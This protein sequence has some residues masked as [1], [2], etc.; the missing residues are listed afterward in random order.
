MSAQP[1]EVKIVSVNT[2][3]NNGCMHSLLQKSPDTDILI[4]QEPWFYTVATVRSDEDPEGTPQKGL[5]HNDMWDA[6]TPKHKT[7]D[8]CKVAIYTHKSLKA[9]YNIKL[10]TDHCLASLTTMVLDLTDTERSTL[11]I[12][13]VYHKRLPRGH[14]LHHLLTHTLDE[15][16]PTILIGDFNTHDPQWSRPTQTPTSWGMAFTEWNDREGLTCLNP[17]D[18]LT[19]FHPTIAEHASIIDLAFANEAL[20]LGGQL[21]T[22]QILDGPVPLTDHATLSLTYY[23]LTSLTF[24]PPPAPTGY[25]ADPERHD[26]WTTAFLKAF[27]TQQV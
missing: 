19:W 17:A 13:N 27:D 16:T 23:P 20:L 12:I 4:I 7:T 1:T 22:L 24:S 21:D 5:P 9:S 18:T 8:T 15:M 14:A 3:H 6:H 26:V 2:N 25:V 11:R 10:R